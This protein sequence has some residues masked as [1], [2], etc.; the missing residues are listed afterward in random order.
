LAVSI[1]S[2]HLI[3]LDNVNLLTETMPG[4]DKNNII[5]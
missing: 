2:L 4:S 1:S 3:S 5:T